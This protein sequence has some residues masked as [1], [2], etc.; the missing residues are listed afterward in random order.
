EAG[1]DALPN[2]LPHIRSG[3]LRALVVTGPSRSAAVPDVPTLSETVQGYEVSG[4]TGIGVPAGTP[5]AIVATQSRD[6]RRPRRRAHRGAAR[7]G[8]RAAD[9]RERG[10]IRPTLA[11]RYRQVGQG[12]EIRRRE[13]RVIG[14]NSAQAKPR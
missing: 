10:G 5:A 8:G 4:W 1:I 14:S 6:Q 7:R 11:A 9:R 3:A 13:A 12:G 2:S